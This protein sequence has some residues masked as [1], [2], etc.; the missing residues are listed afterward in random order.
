VLDVSSCRS[1]VNE[2]TVA[3]VSAAV[4]DAARRIE[5]AHFR[6]T[7]H[8]A[9]ILLGPGVETTAL[10]AVDRDDLVIGAT[11]AARR[12]YGI[13]AERIAAG[14]PASAILGAEEGQDE[15]FAQAERGVVQR[16]LARAG[17]NVT[18]AARAL[19]LS[20]ATLHRKMSRLGLR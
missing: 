1:D 17:G 9:R 19:G 10:L 7:F 14:L 4:G 16:A 11:R 3:L 12:L 15:D 13:S 20:R 6:Q 2:G 5:A 8:H 18:A